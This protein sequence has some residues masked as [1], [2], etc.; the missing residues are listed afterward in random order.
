MLVGWQ[1]VVESAG[2]KSAFLKVKV[3]DLCSARIRQLQPT[4]V[5]TRGAVPSEHPTDIKAHDLESQSSTFC[6]SVVQ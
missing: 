5:F 2:P 1:C 3:L 4:R 6:G